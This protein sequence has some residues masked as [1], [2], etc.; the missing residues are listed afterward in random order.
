MRTNLNVK[1]WNPVWNDDWVLSIEDLQVLPIHS[2]YLSISLKQAYIISNIL[3][4]MFTTEFVF[5]IRFWYSN[6]FGVITVNLSIHSV[7]ITESFICNK[8]SFQH[9]IS[10]LGVCVLFKDIHCCLHSFNLLCVCEGLCV[11]VVFIHSTCRFSIML[12]LL[13]LFVLY[14]FCLCVFPLCICFATT[15]NNN[16]AQKIY[17]QKQ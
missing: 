16:S 10:F 14:Y 3:L 6:I 13:F 5:N 12:L 7:T 4:K 9:Q 2:G 1:Q 15:N 8:F 11:L 17:K